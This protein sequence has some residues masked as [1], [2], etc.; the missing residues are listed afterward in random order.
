M[1]DS[2]AT[3]EQLMQE[4]VAGSHQSLEMLVRR[5]AVGLMTFIQRNVGNRHRAEDLFQEVVFTIWNKRAQYRYPLPLK[6]WLYKIALNRC[7]LDFRNQDRRATELHIESTVVAPPSSPVEAAIAVETAELIKLAVARL[8]SKQ[9]AVVGLRIWN[10]MSYAE[11]A[12]IVGASESTVRSY[13]FH[14]LGALRKS[15][16]R[17]LQ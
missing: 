12:E 3:D 10:S 16:E 13:M 11:V 14:A 15:I 4:I 6:T 17:K 2:L 9:R 1:K 7:R 8:P 5:H